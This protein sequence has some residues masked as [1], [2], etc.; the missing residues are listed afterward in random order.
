MKRRPTARNRGFT[1]IEIMVVITILLIMLGAVMPVYTQ[2]VKRAKEENLR[3]NLDTLNLLIYQYTMDKQKYPKSL[4]DLKSAGYIKTIPKDIT[5][6]EDW[7]T[8]DADGSIMSLDQTDKE[9]IIGVH[10]SSSA[11]AGDGT[12]YSSW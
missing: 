10:S 12:T 7:T 3:K 6:S 1:L 9:G 5:G 11:T 4:E 8:E 2:S